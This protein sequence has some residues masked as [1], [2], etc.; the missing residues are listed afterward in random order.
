M[1]C[2]LQFRILFRCWLILCLIEYQFFNTTLMNIQTSFLLYWVPV[3]IIR[4]TQKA[5]STVHTPFK[6]CRVHF[7]KQNIELTNTKWNYLEREQD[8][9]STQHSILGLEFQLLQTFCCSCSY[10]VIKNSEGSVAP[11]LLQIKVQMNFVANIYVLNFSTKVSSI[12][13]KLQPP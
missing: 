4:I 7:E 13:F 11:Y 6:Q 8:H 12:H 1:Y 3:N 5:L 2:G 10:L 9:D